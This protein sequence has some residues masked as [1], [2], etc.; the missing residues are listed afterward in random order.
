MRAERSGPMGLATAGRTIAFAF[1][2]AA[3]LCVSAAARDTP[4]FVPQL[5]LTD[6]LTTRAAFAPDDTTLLISVNANGRIDLLDISN[7]GRPVKITEIWAA[8][9]DAGFTPGGTT[10]EKIRIV[11]SS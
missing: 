3:L 9:N 5:A 6:L 10:R 8:A 2:G 4:R 1:A 7:P 11:S